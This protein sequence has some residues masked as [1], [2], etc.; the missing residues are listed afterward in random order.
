MAF[1]IVQVE[2]LKELEASL[3]DLPKTVA[4]NTLRRAL[5]KAAQPIHDLARSNA[6]YDPDRKQGTHL[7]DSI[8]ILAKVR[9][10]TGLKEFGETLHGG[11]TREE[12]VSALR[13][14]RREAGGGESRAEV[15]VGTSAPHAHLVEFG[16][17]KMSAEPFLRPAWDA[18]KDQALALISTELATE[19]EKTRARAARKA[20]RLAAKG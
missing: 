3:S 6:P 16:T 14:A 1:T 20:A 18:T 2:G 15:S 17:V 4:R 10:L 5:R 7:R 9:N 12:A 8:F 13:T 11:G 19:I